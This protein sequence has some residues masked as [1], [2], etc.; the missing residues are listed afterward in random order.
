MNE[1]VEHLDDCVEVKPG[2]L[3]YGFKEFEVK[4]GEEVGDVLLG[5]DGSYERVH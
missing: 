4:S 3:A 1:E 2:V 5:S